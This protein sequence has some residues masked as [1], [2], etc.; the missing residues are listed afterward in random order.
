M[1]CLYYA[2]AAAQL[3]VALRDCG[4]LL[5]YFLNEATD[6]DETRSQITKRATNKRD[7]LQFSYGVAPA[8]SGETTQS[9]RDY[10]AWLCS[11][12]LYRLGEIAREYELATYFE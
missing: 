3:V 2:S 9:M 7:W 8:V 11:G 10:V 1:N 5:D 4:R 12:T 6:Q